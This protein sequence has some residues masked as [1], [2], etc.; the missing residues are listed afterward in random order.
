MRTVPEHILVRAY[1]RIVVP[2]RIVVE[3]SVAGEI[4]KTGSKKLFRS[5]FKTGFL[6]TAMAILV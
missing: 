3:K 1:I 2:S 5:K 4:E 6:E